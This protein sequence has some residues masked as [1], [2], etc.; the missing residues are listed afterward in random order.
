MTSTT[1]TIKKQIVLRASRARVWD[2]LTDATKFGAW[3]GAEFD[4]PFSAGQLVRGRVAPTKVDPD[5]AK[6]QAAYAG[7][8]F[9]LHVDRIEPMDRFSFRWHP[10][11]P[12]A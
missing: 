7:L 10:G 9:D 3:F 11:E 12:D 1:D 8:A 6:E 4:G 2:A 5:I